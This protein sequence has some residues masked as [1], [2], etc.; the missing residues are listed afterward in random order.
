MA[1]DDV[2]LEDAGRDYYARQFDGRVRNIRKY[3]KTPARNS[4]G[5][6]AGGGVV[7]VLIVVRIIMAVVFAVGDS[8]SS[9]YNYNN[10][11]PTTPSDRPIEWNNNIQM[12]QQP[13]QIQQADIPE[14]DARRERAFPDPP[15]IPDLNAPLIVPDDDRPRLDKDE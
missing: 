11:A 1:L 2:P 6:V 4:G 10:Y 14:F 8:S 12:E 15:A 5:W 9:S 7:A 3:G 13:W